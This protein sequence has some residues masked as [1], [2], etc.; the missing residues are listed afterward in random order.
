MRVIF[1]GT[2]DI[3]A[4]ILTCLAESRH[5]VVLAVTQPDRPVGR[6]QE[7]KASAVKETAVR[8]GIPVCQ[9]ERIRDA[10][11]VAEVRRAAEETAADIIVVAAFGQLL[12]KEIL[13]LTRFGCVNVHA[14]ILPAYRGAAPIQWAV[15][16]GL[17]KTGITIMQMDEGL[18]TGDIIDILEVPVAAD[19]T[20]G[21]LFEKMSRAAGPFLLKVMDRIE[22]GT[23]K[24]HPQ[25]GP[26]N[27]AAMLSRETGRID[28]SRSVREIDCLVRGVT[29]W[30]GA[31]TMFAGKKLKVLE[32]RPADNP[33]GTPGEMP[34]GASD[35]AVPGTVRIVKGRFFVS[36]G[37]GE[38]ELL[39]VQA[40]GK[41]AMDAADFLRGAKLEN[42]AELG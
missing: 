19:E 40:E 39:R 23:A 29:P 41:K 20:G 10:E 15:I 31:F 2:P 37:N 27:Y 3:A 24:R 1:M 26:S 38:V 32:V 13:E 11:A 22:E 17:E 14:S 9:P 4:D 34:A 30:P 7:L 42:G 25:E 21:S 8:F 35:T 5:E 33:A 6:K 28:W 12:P 18:D 16:D 36:C